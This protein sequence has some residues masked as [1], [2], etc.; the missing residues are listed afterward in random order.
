MMY[1]WGCLRDFKN[2]CNGVSLGKALVKEGYVHLSLY[3]PIRYL[4]KSL[5]IINVLWM[6]RA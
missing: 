5:R 4:G 6:T 3:N 1:L 2:A